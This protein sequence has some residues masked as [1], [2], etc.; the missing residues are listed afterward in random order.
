[1]MTKQPIFLLYKPQLP[2]NIG[3]VARAMG[4][5]GLNNLRIIDPLCDIQDPKAMATAAGAE[6]IL[7]SAI[8]Y[9]TLEEAIA[10]LNWVFGTCAT[11]RH[12]IKEYIPIRQAADR[13]HS[14]L[15]RGEVGI[16]FGPERT[17][18]LNDHLAR[19]HGV[20]Q[21]P[22]N[23]DFSSMNLAQASVI[24]AYELSHYT[25]N[26]Q[27]NLYCGE[28]CPA[29]QQQLQAFLNFLETKLDTINYWRVPEKKPLMKQNLENVFTRLQ[30]TE[31][32]L[33]SLWGMIDLLSKKPK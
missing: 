16:L 21:I 3:A 24:M 14:Q 18:L 2:E 30:P 8:L 22:V 20:I 4:N 17:G 23:P 7:G 11:Q 31:Q 19:C 15:A 10:D 25:A 1:M 29:S 9:A 27:A 5:F 32:D 13:V 6:K 26:A 33:R 12:L 28:T